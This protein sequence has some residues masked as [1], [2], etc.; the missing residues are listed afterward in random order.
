MSRILKPLSQFCRVGARNA[1]LARRVEVSKPVVELDGDEMTRIIWEFIK[2]RLI[3]PYVN[4]ECE[5]YDLG[6]PSRDETYDQVCI[7]EPLPV[8]DHSVEETCDQQRSR[9]NAGLFA[10]IT[11]LSS[12]DHLTNGMG[13]TLSPL[14]LPV[15]WH[16]VQTW[17][18]GY[19]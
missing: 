16:E 6:L 11:Y 15:Q 14:S 12:F 1:S 13:N 8:R 10:P 17:C 19:R 5:Y 4:V 9:N 7:C 2:D 18:T 3:F